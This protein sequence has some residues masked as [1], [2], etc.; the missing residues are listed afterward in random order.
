V[1]NRPV[2]DIGGPQNKTSEER[3]QALQ[4]F[5]EPFFYGGKEKK[6]GERRVD[7]SSGKTLMP[8]SKRKKEKKKPGV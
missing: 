5:I 3:K 2:K 4:N 6:G 1:T 7:N 8:F